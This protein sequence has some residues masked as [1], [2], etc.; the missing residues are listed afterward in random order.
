VGKLF[1]ANEQHILDW[2]HIAR[3]FEAIGKGP[4]KPNRFFMRESERSSA[5]EFGK[6]FFQIS[7]TS[8]SLAARERREMRQP[9]VDTCSYKTQLRPVAWVSYGFPN[10]R[11]ATPR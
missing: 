3:R 1:N 5:P 8:D 11:A 10:V 6:F 7:G 4:I 9:L 2:Y